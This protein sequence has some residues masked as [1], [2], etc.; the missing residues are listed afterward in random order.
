MLQDDHCSCFN[1]TIK[2]S[3]HQIF[4]KLN[5][6]AFLGL[7]ILGAKL[8]L[9]SNQLKLH[10]PTPQ[11]SLLLCLRYIY[12]CHLIFHPTKSL[13]MI[14]HQ[15]RRKIHHHA[16]CHLH[17]FLQIFIHQAS[18]TCPSHAFCCFSI[19]PQIITGQ[20]IYKLHNH[21]CSLWNHL[22]R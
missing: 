7:T 2:D 13:H 6:W 12:Q 3:P 16:S 11:I 4:L 1:S 17:N 9:Q 21:L 18:K 15:A 5:D 20:T 22:H 10:F 8:C 14:C 19:R